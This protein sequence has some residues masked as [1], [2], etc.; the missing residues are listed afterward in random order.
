MIEDRG[1]TDWF[2]LAT[3]GRNHRAAADV[4]CASGATV[5]V[6]DLSYLRPGG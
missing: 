1:V 2:R 3:A 5:W 4:A 6:G